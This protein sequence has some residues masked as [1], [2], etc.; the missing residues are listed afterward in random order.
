[1]VDYFQDIS[2]IQ[3]EG[4][5]LINLLVFKYYNFQ[6]VVLGKIMEEYLCFVLCYWYN[7]CWDGVDVFGGGMFGCLW[8]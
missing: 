5:E 6:E 1:M 4:V 3:Y 2:V 8:L 7:F